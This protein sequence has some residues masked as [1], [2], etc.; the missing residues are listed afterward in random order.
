MEIAFCRRYGFPETRVAGNLLQDFQL[1]LDRVAHFQLSS[2]VDPL[3][4]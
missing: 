4:P 1:L 3:V 2:Q